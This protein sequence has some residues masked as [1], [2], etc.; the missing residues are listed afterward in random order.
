M[1]KRDAIVKFLD[2]LIQIDQISDISSNG[3]QIKGA[4]EVNKIALATDAAMASYQKSVE[5]GCQMLVAH[6]GL[7]WGGIKYVTGRN[8]AHL[9][10]MIT[11]KLNLYAAHLP[12]DM[13]PKLGNNAKLAQMANLTD[14]IPFG[15][16]HGIKLGFSGKLKTPATIE[17]FTAMWD[18]TLPGKSTVLNFGPK[19]ISTVAIVSGR[20][21]S[22]LTEAISK[23]ID[24]LVTGETNHTSFHEAKEAGIH[25]IYLG[26]YR[27]ETVGVKAVGKELEKEFKIKTVFID[28]PTGL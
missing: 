14:V 19:E 21:P 22:A 4:D 20:D 16:Y 15:D 11:N 13:H 18:S 27:S 28:E 3:L 1:P 23:G 2:D 17:S 6:H 5:A 12:L 10:Y 9:E 7:I 26:H 8:H 24:C 25:V